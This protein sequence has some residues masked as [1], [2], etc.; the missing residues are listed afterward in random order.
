[1]KGHRLEPLLL[2]WGSSLLSGAVGGGEEIHHGTRRPTA[3]RDAKEG[4]PCGQEP[5]PRHRPG[6]TR[7][8]GQ[9]GGGKWWRPA[10]QP[11]LE[12]SSR[13]K[14]QLET[15]QQRARQRI[16]RDSRG[17]CYPYRPTAPS[18]LTVMR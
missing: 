8:E 17:W 5:A 11:V 1:M 12:A 2:G 16:Q 13:A 6:A 10:G 7:G 4:A 14:P 15:M 3:T 18:A 9:H